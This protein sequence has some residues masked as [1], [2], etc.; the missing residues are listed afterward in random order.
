MTKP[1]RILLK[2]KIRALLYYEF[3]NKYLTEKIKV[4]TKLKIKTII[5]TSIT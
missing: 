1:P 2:R 3:L 5:K 4:K